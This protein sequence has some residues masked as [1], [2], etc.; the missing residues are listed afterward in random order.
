VTIR[1]SAPVE[2]AGFGMGR[3]DEVIARVREAIAEHLP[4]TSC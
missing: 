4:R 1:F 3:R 2:T